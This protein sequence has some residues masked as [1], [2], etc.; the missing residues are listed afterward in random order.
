MSEIPEISAEEEARLNQLQK[1]P[2][3]FYFRLADIKQMYEEEQQMSMFSFPN[4]AS[5]TSEEVP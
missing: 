4:D 3:V 2:P 1:Y 5:E